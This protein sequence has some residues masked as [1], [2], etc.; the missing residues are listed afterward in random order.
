MATLIFPGAEVLELLAHA[1]AAK[2]H[3][4]G[5]LNN[6][7]PGPGLLFVK[8]D[9][10]YLM[11]NGQPSLVQKPGGTS[12]KVVYATGY[13]SPN[14]DTGEFSDYQYEKI[15]AAAGGDDFAEFIEA[16]SLDALQAG[17]ELHIVLTPTTMELVIMNSRQTTISKTS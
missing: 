4:A 1:K 16:K 9:G 7:L 15:R 5:Y 11:S 2:S 14:S 12:S 10:I 13:E 6:P 8:D 3:S 17:D